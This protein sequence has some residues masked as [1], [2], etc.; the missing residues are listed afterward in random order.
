MV[1]ILKPYTYSFFSA[2]CYC[3]VLSTSVMGASSSTLSSYADKLTSMPSLSA[4]S[5]AMAQEMVDKEIRRIIVEKAAQA[6]KTA[7]ARALLIDQEDE[8]DDID[9]FAFSSHARRLNAQQFPVGDEWESLNA[10]VDSFQIFIPE[11]DISQD[12]LG[13]TLSIKVNGTC[14]DFKVVDLRLD[15]D[16]GPPAAT[17]DDTKLAYKLQVLGVELKCFLNVSW[18]TGVLDVEDDLKIKIEFNDTNL[19][20]AIELTGAPPKT[21][22]LI[23]CKAQLGIKTL[24]SS[25]GFSSDIINDLNEL[26]VGAV[27]DETA[28]ISELLCDALSN[29]TDTVDEALLAL[30]D[31]LEPFLFLDVPPVDPLALEESLPAEPALVSFNDPTGI[32][33]VI[34]VLIDNFAGVINADTINTLI[35][36]ALL[37]ENGQFVLV[38]ETTLP[39]EQPPPAL[40]FLQDD[41]LFPEECNPLT[42]LFG[43]GER[44]LAH[45]MKD[46]VNDQVTEINEAHRRRR[47]QFENFT[48][49]DLLGNNTELFVIN[50]IAPMNATITGLNSFT[51]GAP[52]T[53]IGD[54][55][56]LTELTLSGFQLDLAVALDAAINNVTIQEVLTL[57]IDVS[58]IFVNASFVL[59]LSQEETDTWTIGTFLD[60][61]NLQACLL[62]AL[63]AAGAS[64]LQITVGDI[65]VPMVTDFVD[66]GVVELTNT[67]LEGAVC[68]YEDLI[69][70]AVPGFFQQNLTIIINDFFD[71]VIDLDNSTCPDST[72]GGNGTTEGDVDFD[73]REGKA[74]SEFSR[75][76]NA[77]T[78]YLDFR[79]LLLPP[80]QAKALGGSGRQQYGDVIGLAYSALQEQL[81]AVDDLTGLPAINDLLGSEPLGFNVSFGTTFDTSTI[82]FVNLLLEY[83]KFAASNIRAQNLNTLVPPI[84]V[85]QPTEQPHV[86]SNIF[87]FGPVPGRELNG[88]I[89]VLLEVDGADSPL[90]LKNDMDMNAVIGEL[91]LDADVKVLISTQ[92]FVQFPLGDLLNLDCWF[93]LVED[94]VA[95]DGT[96]E[97]SFE[98]NSLILSILELSLGFEC[99]DCT[100]SVFPEVMALLDSAGAVSSLGE[101]MGPL[102]EEIA[103]GKGT[104]PFLARLL[105]MGEVAARNCPH[106][107]LFNK[108]PVEMPSPEFAI[109]DLSSKSIDAAVYTGIFGAQ[110][111]S[112][113]FAD[114]HVRNN[115]SLSDPLSGEMTFNYTGKSNVLDWTALDETFLPIAGDALDFLRDFL[116][117]SSTNGEPGINEVVADLLEDDGS[118]TLALDAALDLIE[119][120]TV[121]IGTLTVKGLDAF[122]V[123]DILEPFGPQTL[124]NSVTLSN[125][126]VTASFSIDATNTTE[127]PQAYNISFDVTGINT[128]IYLFTAID[129]DYVESLEIGSLLFIDNLIPCLL[130]SAYDM[131]V[132]AIRAAI[133]GI[134][135]PIVEGLM[136]ETSAAATKS[137]DA[138][139][140]TYEPLFVE[141]AELILDNSI[142]RVLNEFV[143]DFIANVSGCV[144]AEEL[145]KDLS[146]ESPY[147]DWRDLL[148]PPNESLALGGSGTQPYGDLG[149]TAYSLLLDQLGASSATGELLGINSL[150]EDFT[151]NQTGTKGFYR[152]AGELAAF[153]LNDVPF[154][155]LNWTNLS[156]SLSAFD[157]RL[158]NLNTITSPLILAHPTDSPY[159][160]HNSISFGPNATNPITATLGALLGITGKLRSLNMFNEFDIS[161]IM[162]EIEVFAALNVYLEKKKLFLF[163]LQDVLELDCW[164]SLFPST[165]LATDT[166]ALDI[167]AMITKLM[168]LSTEVD[169]LN[170]TSRT[171]SEAVAL[172]EGSGASLVLG[173]RLGLLIDNIA[174]SDT[175]ASLLGDFLLF[176]DEAG[177]SCPHHPLFNI[178]STAVENSSGGATEISLPPLSSLS[179]DTILYT[180]V[181]FAE[182]AVIVGA[183]NHL[184]HPGETVDP[185]EG[186]IE[187]PEGIM[188]INWTNLEN[189]T[190]PF[191]DAGIS[192]ARSFLGPSES[193]TG[194]IVIGANDVFGG[195]LDESGM[196][197]LDL[198]LGFNY[199]NLQITVSSLRLGGLDS[200]TEMD[201]LYPID[202]LTLENNAT[203][204]NVTVGIEISLDVMDTEEPPNKLNLTFD[205]ID[206]RISAPLVVVVDEVKV[207]NLALGDLLHLANIFPCLL[208]TTYGFE[209]Q[210]LLVSVESISELRLEGL[211]PD[212]DAAAANASMALFQRY[213]G[214]IKESIPLVFKDTLRPVLNSFLRSFDESSCTS[215]DKNTTSRYI[216]FREFFLESEGYSPYGD[217]VPIILDI[218]DEQFFQ[219]DPETQMPRVNDAIGSFTLD[220]SGVS[221]TLLLPGNIFSFDTEA[222]SGLGIGV[223]GLSFSDARIEHLNT[224]GQPLV[225]LEPNMTRGDLLDN[226]G[227]FGTDLNPLRF[228][229]RLSLSLMG[230]L[231]Q[232][233]DE[234][235]IFGELRKAPVFAVLLARL[236]AIEILN[237]PVEESTNIDCWFAALAEPALEH[238]A[239]GS[240]TFDPVLSLDYLNIAYQS[241]RVSA[242][243]FNCTNRGLEVVPDLLEILET[244]T[245]KNV[246]AQRNTELIIDLLKSDFAQVW[247]LRFLQDSI[248]SCS[249]LA[250]SPNALLVYESPE[251]PKLNEYNIETGV[252]SV[253]AAIQL[254]LVVLAETLVDI[255]NAEPLFSDPEPD[256]PP[257]TRLVDWTA[258]DEYA[259]GGLVLAAIDGINGFLGEEI[260]DEETGEISLSI[261]DLIGNPLLPISLNEF[262]FEDTI[263]IGLAGLVININGVTISGLDTFT[264]FNVANITGPTMLRHMFGWERLQLNVKLEVDIT[265]FTSANLAEA[266]D[267]GRKLQN[268]VEY[269]PN[270]P[271]NDGKFQF[272]FLIELAD[273]AVDAS[274]FV[275]MDYE[276]LKFLE[277]GNFLRIEYILPCIQATILHLELT[278]LLVSVGKV[279]KMQV[280]GWKSDEVR[281]AAENLE[282][283]LIDQFGET[284]ASIS[285][286]AFKIALRPLINSLINGYLRDSDF[287][288]DDFPFDPATGGFVD[289]RDLLL[290]PADSVALG[291]T[292]KGQYGDLFSSI[293][294]FSSLAVRFF[295]LPEL[296]TLE[297]PGPLV[298]N[299]LRFDVRDFQS[300]FR[301]VVSDLVIENANSVGTLAYTEP[302]DGEPH[303]VNNTVEFGIGRKPI[304]IRFRV[305][306][307]FEGLGGSLDGVFIENDFELSLDIKKLTIVLAA[308]AKVREQ[309]FVEFPLRDMLELNCWLATIPAPELDSS[310]RRLP[311]S[312]DTLSLEQI[313]VF[314]EELN[315][316]ISCYN[317][318]SPDFQTW[319]E[320][321]DDPAAS[322]ELTRV[323]NV[324]ME[325]L[326]NRFGGDFLQSQLDR[327][328]VDAPRKCPHTDNYDPDAPPFAFSFNVLTEP[329]PAPYLWFLLAIVILL[330]L[331]GAAALMLRY[332][333]LKRHKKWLASLPSERVFLIQQNQEKEEHLEIEMNELTTSMF[334]SEEVHWIPR[335]LIPIIVVVNIGFF[336]SGHLSLGGRARVDFVIAGQTFSVENFY[337]F[338]I[339]QST[340][341]L[342]Y[343]GGEALAGIILLFSGIW[344]YT[345]QLIT[346]SLWY[347][348]TTMVSVT[349][350]GKFLMWLDI[351]A[352]W[353]MIDI[354]VI[355]ITIVGFRY[356]LYLCCANLCVHSLLA[357]F[358][359]KLIQFKMLLRPQNWRRQSTLSIPSRR[360]LQRPTFGYSRMGSLC[361]FACSADVTD[362]FALYC[363]VPP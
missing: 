109:P 343:N 83:V 172:V 329:E 13:F 88:S 303:K 362:K 98:I 218:L 247:I 69:I 183:D 211:L 304:G 23:G 117:S 288:C 301:V 7:A 37:D 36:G 19:G 223:T 62:S 203:L 289:F 26:V 91:D 119:G 338:S 243:C 340:L 43:G 45:M 271:E 144:S 332:T 352:K 259:N 112:V 34:R 214:M 111:A 115:V 162:E 122:Q 363:H 107:E 182:V 220:Q 167:E 185:L 153:A 145:V 110:V 60:T 260:V 239:S 124:K 269:N 232:T 55:T 334:T 233:R 137:I 3:F 240:S 92:S 90:A 99:L 267:F 49:D 86:L 326:A 46:F 154:D 186:M 1:T 191:L 357:T 197:S 255:E 228:A 151:E 120:Y 126:S 15:Y 32:G 169:C 50:G 129:M 127:P 80:D 75:Q 54:Q 311:G 293:F 297:L 268:G 57:S 277:L 202:P 79:D 14:T 175:A 312:A 246:L 24:Q 227:T 322:E 2:L 155:F 104:G 18:N 189:S 210:D 299:G 176:G 230:D 315:M 341:D 287:A 194:E 67:A 121:T 148:L 207:G 306:F 39:W 258:L 33:S 72:L 213:G 354:F 324:L 28:F 73:F 244:T 146:V 216:D 95:A 160:L 157:V 201:V 59:G 245:A 48:L 302:I 161:G 222:L 265:N 44:R 219:N 251:F 229:L 132:P 266:Y 31:A 118:F 11:I 344:P 85:L 103:G 321:L 166:R 102:I 272:D 171:L 225:V 170:C 180:A 22:E 314:L 231:F 193:E 12:L 82:T 5:K 141:A 164:F 242:S 349:R 328:L 226:K 295:L 30:N 128:T 316:G 250:D 308:L 320:L 21:T 199:S 361:E 8:Y 10:I 29:A 58:D 336:L 64:Q 212:T 96:R 71:C 116:G 313:K 41:G 281:V 156:A 131:N 291:G 188:L 6:N 165:D 53:V 51:G 355:F 209:L 17:F 294:G 200:F 178:T 204:E 190:V 35:E 347:L 76:Q 130:E 140:N 285:P 323:A 254:G 65:G 25:G 38:L 351:L 279:T 61:S 20:L 125:L 152:L 346:L 358:S 353:S 275:A 298:D 292:G 270:D 196:F 63:E 282:R 253:T 237:L 93:S 310:G 273:V 235:D 286:N 123:F 192:L 100:G 356:A 81:I 84:K 345:K 221:G 234:L 284:I 198:D 87:N 342:W 135:K 238:I 143:N 177:R 309:S 40:R 248:T 278:D 317:C 113:I 163:P 337:N 94:P 283:A 106:H 263:N 360:Y 114:A 261:N 187:R 47:L 89:T 139:F 300:V 280:S 133:G 147:V 318:T 305:Y 331:A 208:S 264:K 359:F 74:V 262:E 4:L 307:K 217:I 9:S 249:Y 101:V 158:E 348:P 168:S 105:G 319:G 290:G 179:L 16:K 184:Q 325:D 195:L 257:G 274:T 138:L 241:L 149:S 134:S 56:F 42:G 97:N 174:T 68:A 335:Y 108:T 78:R 77:N 52:L 327:L 333:V 206:L 224:V 205:I 350:R 330:L 215:M 236:G 150:V 339:A 159:L 181:L 252:F 136:P 296:G 66:P 27:R 142:R 276:L 256:I 70:A 173:E